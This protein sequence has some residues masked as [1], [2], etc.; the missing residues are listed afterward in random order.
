[1]G[2][3]AKGKALRRSG[4]RPEDDIWVSGHLGDAAL[5]LAHQQRRIVLEAGEIDECAFRTAQSHAP[6]RPG[7]AIDRSCPQ[8]HRYF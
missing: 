3:V 1:M 2:E 6:G 5:A 8:R 4:A 7:A